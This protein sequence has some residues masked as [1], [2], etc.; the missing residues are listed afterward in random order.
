MQHSHRRAR[1]GQLHGHRVTCLH[2]KQR[3]QINKELANGKE[4][5]FFNWNSWT[6]C[7]FLSP[8]CQLPLNMTYRLTRCWLSCD[9]RVPLIGQLLLDKT[10]DSGRC[11]CDIT[12]FWHHFKIKTTV[13]VSRTWPPLWSL[14][15]WE[16]WSGEDGSEE[17][18]H[19]ETRRADKA[20][21]SEES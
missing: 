7:R 15:K 10:A 3:M 16:R 1:A 13:F 12:V 17:R 14:P 8:R 2:Y 9:H 11:S 21:G 19:G 4:A 20:G 5:F 18:T 6:G